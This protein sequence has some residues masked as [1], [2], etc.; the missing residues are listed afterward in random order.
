LVLH[1]RSVRTDAVPQYDVREAKSKLSHLL[2]LV[3]FGERVIICGNG[4]PVAE[5][6]KCRRQRDR[7]K[8]GFAAH[9]VT[10]TPGWEK[11]MTIEEAERF[12]RIS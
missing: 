6:V 4:K 3:E 9:Q 11:A 2:K 12:L 1:A 5:L 10:E 8:V 7:V